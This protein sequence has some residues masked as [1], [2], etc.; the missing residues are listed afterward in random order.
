MPIIAR[1][2]IDPDTPPPWRDSRSLLL[3][4]I[5]GADEQPLTGGASWAG[6][7]DWVLMPGATGLDLPPVTPIV[8]TAPG[9]DGGWLRGTTV[10]A[11]QVYLPLFV[12]SPTSH[13]DYLDRRD[14]LFAFLDEYAVDDLTD[15]DGTLELV[16][17]SARG[18]RYLRVVYSGGL[19]GDEGADQSGTYWGKYGLNLT[20]SDPYWRATEETVLEF[21]SVP[22]RPF[23][24]TTGHAPWPRRLTPAVS[25]AGGGLSVTVP[26]RVPV[27]PVI[28]IEGPSSATTVT[29][30]GP[31][32]EATAVTVGS[33][34]AGES[35][36]L[37]TDPRRR[38]ATVA[39]SDAWARVAAAPRFGRLRPGTQSIGV[40]VGGVS[41]GTVVRLRYRAA[42]RTAW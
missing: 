33:V 25:L 22:G 20:A 2:A 10:G 7:Y 29:W 36:R 15:A 40:G 34:A 27:W 6:G 9:L 3:R 18:E 39:G 26:G 12:A 1:I 24:S 19:E 13:A 37:S 14:R 16:A 23:L 17:A 11:R 5:I 31:R 21:G 35:F 42:H 8:E 38:E 4:T 30:D 32:D 41:A 28:E